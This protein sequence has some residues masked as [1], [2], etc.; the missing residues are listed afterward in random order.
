MVESMC[1]AVWSMRKSGEAVG[2]SLR[3][4]TLAEVEAGSYT[5]AGLLNAAFDSAAVG[6]EVDFACW[7]ERGMGSGGP[8]LSQAVASGDYFLRPLPNE[9]KKCS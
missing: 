4:I 2:A 9:M 6:E 8:C 1:Q 3:F 7:S 5:E